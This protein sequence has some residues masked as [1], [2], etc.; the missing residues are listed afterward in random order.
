MWEAEFADL[1]LCRNAT[2][3][4]AEG[5]GEP[6]RAV[7]SGGDAHRLGGQRVE[8]GDLGEPQIEFADFAVRRDATDL[9]AG[10]VG[11]P[12]RP[13]RPARQR[14][15]LQLVALRVAFEA[16]DEVFADDA[17]AR[18]APDLGAGRLDEPDR[19]VRADGQ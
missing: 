5:L 15:E 16:R 12:Q 18:D 10:D 3:A 13:V 2:D 9:V 19:F 4:V 7:G 1:A 17:I 11:E 8:V 14:L 6:D